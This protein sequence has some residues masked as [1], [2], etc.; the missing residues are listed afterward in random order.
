[1]KN[2]KN[3]PLKRQGM[4]AQSLGFNNLAPS[5]PFDYSAVADDIDESIKVGREIRRQNELD[6]RRRAS[7][8]FMQAEYSKGL[9]IPSDSGFSAIDDYAATVSRGL[10]DRGSQLVT[11]L[12]NNRISSAEFGRLYGTLQNQ[13]GQIKP[14][15]E[16][17]QTNFTTYATD[18]AQGVLS[19][20]NDQ[21]NEDFFQAGIEGRGK[22][23]V[24]ENGVVV[25]TGTTKKGKPFSIPANQLSK[26]PR[27]IKK[28][29]SFE[30]LTK[31]I[32]DAL[33][34]PTEQAIVDP[35][36]GQPTGKFNMSS[37]PA[38]LN[39]SEFSK[40]VRSSFDSFVNENKMDGLKS[41]AV[42]YGGFTYD[43]MD[44][45]AN[46]GQF[47]P[48]KEDFTAA[49]I[50]NIPGILEEMS[51]E[52]FANKLEFE[53]EKLWIAKTMDQTVNKQVA[54]WKQKEYD[55]QIA[56]IAAADRANAARV[57]A[58]LT[59]NER[60]QQRYTRIL[61]EL[62]PPSKNNYSTWLSKVPNLK[63]DIDETD[64][65]RLAVFEKGKDDAIEYIEDEIVNNPNLFAQYIAA[66]FYGLP[67]TTNTFNYSKENIDSNIIPLTPTK[68]I[69]PL[70][71]V[72]KFFNI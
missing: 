68:K 9:M 15:L 19:G 13:V 21:E 25:F 20:A 52:N 47:I 37:I 4:I 14:M 36:T 16:A 48:S 27:P 46:S 32:A 3:S 60:Q 43:E 72:K 31:P 62:P 17:L 28:V 56:K 71:R 57:Q 34:T 6:K 35:V 8:G 5:R 64:D 26:M 2:T 30:S 24:D 12:E 45:M 18:N 67:V 66:K 49:E 63:F 29:D 65:G 38:D 70:N 50:E 41:L 1:M 33:G 51:G 22:L 10:A 61:Q 7:F 40:A 23:E 11:D 59:A 42:D 58:G 55:L 39:N 69:G 53:M 44:E 54:H